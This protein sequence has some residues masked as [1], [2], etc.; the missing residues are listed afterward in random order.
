MEKQNKKTIFN[1]KQIAEY[2]NCSTSMIRK[3]INNNEIPYFKIRKK[4]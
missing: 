4:L 2:L 3:M 1:I